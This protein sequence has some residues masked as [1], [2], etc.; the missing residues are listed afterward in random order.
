MRCRSPAGT[1]ARSDR[2]AATRSAK[3]VARHP[4]PDRDQGQERAAKAVEQGLATKAAAELDPARPV[5]AAAREAAPALDSPIA[6]PAPGA[7]T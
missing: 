1:A 7:A 4:A 6:R 2:S 3:A 5:Q